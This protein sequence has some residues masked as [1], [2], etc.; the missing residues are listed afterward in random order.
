MFAARDPSRFAAQRTAPLR[1][2]E[3]ED[4]QDLV[5]CRDLRTNRSIDVTDAF[6][7]RD[8]CGK[9]KAGCGIVESKPRNGY[10]PLKEFPAGNANNSCQCSITRRE[11]SVGCRPAL[12]LEA[13]K[14][15]A[16]IFKIAREQSQCSVTYGKRADTALLMCI[17]SVT[18]ACRHY[19]A[20]M[21]PITRH[22]KLSG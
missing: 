8:D 13:E 6:D 19:L 12:G 17:H 22:R 9:A 10:M 18:Q 4:N 14:G 21:H 11:P 15:Y 1:S 2:G 20:H 7:C 16:S 5:N 3:P